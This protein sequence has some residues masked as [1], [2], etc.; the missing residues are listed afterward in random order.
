MKEPLVE[1]CNS[2]DVPVCPWCCSPSDDVI[3]CKQ[4]KY[5]VTCPDCHEAY[6]VYVISQCTTC[7]IESEEN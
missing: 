2:I 1:E 6:T 4:E 5:T 7:P 3:D